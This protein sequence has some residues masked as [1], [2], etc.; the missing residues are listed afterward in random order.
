MICTLVHLK[1]YSAH[2]IRPACTRKKR[3]RLLHGSWKLGHIY[4]STN[5]RQFS[6]WK[7]FSVRSPVITNPVHHSSCSGPNS[8]TRIMC[9]CINCHR[10]RARRATHGWP[11]SSTTLKSFMFSYLPT[12]RRQR[13]LSDHHVYVR[14]LCACLSLVHESFVPKIE[15][16]SLSLMGAPWPYL[17]STGQGMLLYAMRSDAA[18]K[19]PESR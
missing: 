15:S 4:G 5:A 6:L 3:D 17:H 14:H 11:L 13:R 1:F 18:D 10:P 8:I 7:W 19:I 9:A 12:I 16:I 2:K